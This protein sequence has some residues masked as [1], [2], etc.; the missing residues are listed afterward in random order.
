MPV[1]EREYRL[2]L[3]GKTGVGKSTTGNAILGE[4]AFTAKLSAT[5]ITK[6]TVCK[7]ATNRIN[8]RDVFIAD[9]PGLFDTDMTQADVTKEIVRCVG[10]TSPGPHAVI[11]VLSVTSRFT[12]EERNTVDHF[13]KHFGKDLYKFVIVLFTGIDNLERENTTLDAYMQNIPT[14]LKKVIASAGNRYIGFNNKAEPNALESQVASL[15]GMIDAMVS[16]NGGGCYTNEM[17][18][19]AEAELLRQERELRRQAEEKKMQEEARIRA[20]CKEGFENA[21]RDL[22]KKHEKEMEQVRNVIRGGIG[23][24]NGGDGGFMSILGPLLGGLVG[25]STKCTIQ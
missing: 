23:G 20:E 15:F 8:G 22:E 6:L 14:A 11:L 24:G 19:R 17:Y 21:L 13:I 7:A 12:D 25:A 16:T 4:Q 5:S 9:T 1:Q 18:Q 10:M 2:V 3:L